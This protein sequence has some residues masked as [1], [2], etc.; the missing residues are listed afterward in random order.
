M[1]TKEMVDRALALVAEGGG[2]YEYFFPTWTTL[3][4]LS[5]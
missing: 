3:I 2:N 1:V 4:G 5:R